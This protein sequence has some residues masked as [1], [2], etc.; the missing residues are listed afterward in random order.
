MKKK[1]EPL[2]DCIELDFRGKH[3]VFNKVECIQDLVKG[4][5]IIGEF[6][7]KKHMV[8]DLWLGDRID[9][10]EYHS[11]LEN[12]LVSKAV[13]MFTKSHVLFHVT[14]IDE[15]TISLSGP[16]GNT[17]NLAIIGEDLYVIKPH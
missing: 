5:L 13:P 15:K 1:A 16:D 9:D 8:N 10:S 6:N 17:I 12:W 3:L 2:P 14:D 7:L 4:H 11:R